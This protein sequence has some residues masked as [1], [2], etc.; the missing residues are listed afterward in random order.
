MNKPLRIRITLDRSDW[1]R[2]LDTLSRAVTNLSV[3]YAAAPRVVFDVRYSPSLMARFKDTLKQI[4]DLRANFS[5]MQY[6]LVD[7]DGY[8]YKRPSKPAPAAQVVPLS[9]P[10]VPHPGG[11]NFVSTAW[12]VEG[13]SHA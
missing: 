1:D 9:E 5:A 4:E 13:M 6:E 11:V 2:Y 3:L 10:Q 12:M 7:D 8:V